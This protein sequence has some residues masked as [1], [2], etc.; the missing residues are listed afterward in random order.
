MIV[1]KRASENSGGT[2]DFHHTLENSFEKM[3]STT[4]DSVNF[5]NNAGG[6]HLLNHNYLP[7][8]IT[9][10]GIIGDYS[11]HSHDHSSIANT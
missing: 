7:F 5:S 11:G 3:Y 4:S 6:G 8:Y 9:Q 2:F 10:D 1:F